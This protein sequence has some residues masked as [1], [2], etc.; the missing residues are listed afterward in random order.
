MTNPNPNPN[1]DLGPTYDAV[2][3]TYQFVPLLSSDCKGGVVIPIDIQLPG[4][5]ILD[6]VN[7]LTLTLT[8]I[9]T[10]DLALFLT[11]I[12]TLTLILGQH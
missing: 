12:L 2:S 1:L 10:L 5:R 6:G 4:S 7:T 9:S 3:P 11:L 8:L